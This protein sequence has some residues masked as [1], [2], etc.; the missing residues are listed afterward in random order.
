MARLKVPEHLTTKTTEGRKPANGKAPPA[1]LATAERPKIKDSDLEELKTLVKSA[2]ALEK[3]IENGEALLKD[4]KGQDEKLLTDDIPQ[5]MQELGIPYIALEKS[6]N[7]PGF[8]AT[9]RPFYAASLAKPKKADQPDPRPEGFEY[10]EEIGHG[11]LIKQV[12]AYQFP[13]H[14]DPELIHKFVEEANELVVSVMK[15]TNVGTKKKPK[16]VAK[17]LKLEIPFPTVERSVHGGT[18][19]AWL[20]RQVEQEKFVPILSKIGGFLGR[21]VE[22]K[23]ID[24]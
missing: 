15:K 4:L 17:K 12:V 1:Y 11:D 20:K 5:K 14:T 7:E 22:I 3:R 18:L 21:R 9:N 6:G 23:T 8:V 2:R 24:E 13:V 19:T 10:L 16:W